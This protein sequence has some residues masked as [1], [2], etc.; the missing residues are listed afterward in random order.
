MLSHN[1]QVDYSNEKIQATLKRKYTVKKIRKIDKNS[2]DYLKL[3]EIPPELLCGKDRNQ[4]DD[5]Y[6]NHSS[7][8]NSN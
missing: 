5:D 8:Y 4:N 3:L 7:N 2:L 1:L 6:I